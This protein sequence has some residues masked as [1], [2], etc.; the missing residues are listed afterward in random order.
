VAGAS[1]SRPCP[2][3]PAPCRNASSPWRNASSPWRN[4]NRRDACWP[5]QPGRLSSATPP[6]PPKKN[7]FSFGNR[8]V[9]GAS[10]SRPCP[11]RPAPRWMPHLHGGIPTGGMPCWPRQPGRLSSATPPHPLLPKKFNF[12]KKIL[13]PPKKCFSTFSDEFLVCPTV[14]F[15]RKNA[16][17][18]Q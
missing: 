11:E 10:C 5:R 18:T 6:H 16:Q 14:F 4:S 9:A 13:R 7:K 17:D 1:C 12:P 8:S 3:R 15:C 2:E